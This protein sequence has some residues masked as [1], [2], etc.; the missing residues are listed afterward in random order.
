MQLIVSFHLIANSTLKSM[1]KLKTCTLPILMGLLLAISGVCKAQFVPPTNFSGNSP[2]GIPWSTVATGTSLP[3]RTGAT[4]PLNGTPGAVVFYDTITGELAIDPHGLALSTVIITY[5]WGTTNVNSSTTGPFNFPLGALAS[6]CSTCSGNSYSSA[7]GST[8]IRTFPAKDPATSGLNPTTIQT[9]IA[10]TIGPP[11]SAS[12]SIT[13]DADNIASSANGKGTTG[14][15][16]V[17]N[18]LS[19][20]LNLPWSFGNVV[21][22]DSISAIKFGNFKTVGQG[23]NLNANTLGYGSQQC[24]FLY[25]VSGVTGNQV[26]PVIPWNGVALPCTPITSTSTATACNSYTWNGTTYTSSG[27][28]TWTGTNAG[29]C[30]ST[31]TLNLT[32][33]PQPSQ[34]TIA[35]YQ[36]ATFNTTTC[37]WDITGSQP[38]QPS[39]ACYQTAVFDTVACA[40]SISES[41][42]PCVDFDYPDFSDT[43]G[44]IQISTFGV[45]SNAIKLTNSGTN[46]DVG[47]VY[48]SSSVRY[49][50][51]FKFQWTFEISGGSGSNGG[52]DGYCLQWAT[53]NNTNGSGAASNLGMVAST[54]TANA[55]KFL[56]FSNNRM[57][58]YKRNSAQLNPHNQ[59]AWSVPDGYLDR[60]VFY[61]LDYDHDSSRAHFYSSLINVKPA[62]P[63]VV[64]N[65]FTFDTTAYFIG[66]GAGTGAESANHLLKAMKLEFSAVDEPQSEF[67]YPYF[68]N[69]I[70]A[71]LTTV[72]T[73]GI[74]AGRLRLTSASNNNVGN[75]YRSATA[76]YNRDFLLEWEFE[77]SGGDGYDGF[78]VQ[79]T[80]DNTATGQG[81]GGAG[82]IQQSSTKHFVRFNTPN[83]STTNPTWFTNNVNTNLTGAT[84]FSFRRRAWYWL[85]Y[86]HDSSKA[87]LYF[88]ESPSRPA[89]PQRVL[90]GF[91]FSDTAYYLGFGAATGGLNQNHYLRGLRLTYI[92]CWGISG[93]QPAQPSGTLPCYQD[94]VF[95]SSACNWDIVG[96]QP[97][98]PSIACYQSAAFNSSTCLWAAWAA[99]PLHP[100]G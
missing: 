5:T 60:Q 2:S 58:W 29:G 36:Q 42:Q 91:S 52:A 40:W 28:Y 51:D 98:Q 6:S 59:H 4:N 66:F 33:T 63:Q 78:C 99:Y 47:N 27:T 39:I 76:T 38:V 13:G 46:N 87:Y 15:S 100:T 62:R 77:C 96:T 95:N 71:G 64:L 43:T 75:V 1:F 16:T 32:I 73:D 9:R 93:T 80:T 8:G 56:T 31:A 82:A 81:G 21:V 90:N 35:C 74:D 12:L 50:R 14:G 48:R 44:T 61:W 84:S 25:T 45:Q 24:V 88:S 67:F 30:D 10:L 18:N 92:P 79:W 37:Q 23:S 55:L 72:S 26:G 41:N 69:P 85:E 22:P 97:V 94:Y 68:N 65:N 83:G 70:N 11:L 19:G 34:P 54:S 7:T 49:N 53:S 86:D 57:E 17:V 89:T 3:I 20:F